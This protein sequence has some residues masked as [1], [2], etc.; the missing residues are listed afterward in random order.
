MS[1]GTGRPAVTSPCRKICRQDREAGYCIGCGRTVREVFMWFELPE[2][3]RERIRRELPARLER[4]P[5][6]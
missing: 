1:E 5:R 2:I 3:E 6:A 4:L